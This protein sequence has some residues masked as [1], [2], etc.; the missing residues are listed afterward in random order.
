VSCNRNRA[1]AE[2]QQR[3]ALAALVA[4]ARL[5]VGKQQLLVSHLARRTG[6]LYR[7]CEEVLTAC[8]GAASSCTDEKPGA[9]HE[10]KARQE[11]L[12]Q[13]CGFVYAIFQHRRKSVVAF[14][15]VPVHIQR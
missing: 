1:V 7:L 15:L 13:V 12:Q 4:S 3:E 11:R 8:G 6:L 2:E 14:A 9:H 10:A 5:H